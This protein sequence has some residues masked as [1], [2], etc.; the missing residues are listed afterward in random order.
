MARDAARRN[1]ARLIIALSVAAVLAVFVL[2]TSIAGAG[3]PQIQP[4]DLAAHSGEVLLVGKVVSTAG[5]SHSDAGLRF[6]L[7]NVT[8]HP[9]AR[10]RV[11]YHGSV[12]DLYRVGREVVV[13]GKM[14]DGTFVANTDSLSTKCPSKYAPAKKNT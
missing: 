1:P 3:T 2:Y 5:D 8:G 11:V 7:R 12:P 14:R 9:A 10:A 13:T 4:A 6:T